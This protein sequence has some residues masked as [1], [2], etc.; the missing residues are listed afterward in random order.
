MGKRMFTIIGAACLVILVV[1]M[2]LYFFTDFGHTPDPNTASKSK[3]STTTSTTVVGSTTSE[4]SENKQESD[5]VADLVA[6]LSTKEKVGQLLL[7]RV[8][9]E[10]AL[11]DIQEYHL[12]GLFI[13]W[14]GCG[15]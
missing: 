1:I 14:P 3:S 11:D 15:R 8:P 10:N 13:V 9:L 4:S 5:K 6:E 2:G 7:A 12:G